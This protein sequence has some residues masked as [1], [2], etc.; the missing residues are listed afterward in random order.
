MTNLALLGRV[1]QLEAL[2]RVIEKVR[3]G[4]VAMISLVGLAGS[5]RTALLDVYQERL[6]TAGVETRRSAL[7]PASVSAS[8]GLTDALGISLEQPPTAPLALLVSEAQWAD[9]TSLANLQGLLAGPNA[10]VLLVASHSEII[11]YPELSFRQLSDT[12]GRV[13]YSSNTGWNHSPLP[14]WLLPPLPKRWP[15]CSSNGRVVLLKI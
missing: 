1:Q 15:A 4:G 12:A 5:G 14:N 8:G 10:G 2:E 11:D 9:G 6:Q 7:F 3:A 13:G